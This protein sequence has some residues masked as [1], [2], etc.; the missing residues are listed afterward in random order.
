MGDGIADDGVAFSHDGKSYAT[1][2][3]PEVP[4]SQP[5]LFN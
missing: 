5:R 3:A 4:F 2:A 1:A